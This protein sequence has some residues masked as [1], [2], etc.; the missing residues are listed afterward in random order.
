[1]PEFDLYQWERIVM[2]ARLGPSTKL[3][4]FAL[5]THADPDGT[6]VKPGLARLAVLTEL[7]YATVKRA[8][9]ELM[10]AGL[11]E[12]Y[13]RGNRRRG[14]GD[15]YRL[16]LAEDVLERVE[17]LSP[18][19]IEDAADAITEARA[20]AETARRA[21]KDQGS[22]DAPEPADQG[23][24]PT[25]EKPDQG[26]GNAPETGD[27][28]PPVS[29][30]KPDQGSPEIPNTAIRAHRQPVLGLTSDP[31]PTQVTKPQQRPAPDHLPA[32]P[33]TAH[34]PE[35][36]GHGFRIRFRADGSSACACCRWEQRT[37][38]STLEA[39]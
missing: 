17:W 31:L 24:P 3:V 16:I 20:E 5:R 6:R 19:Q 27:Q 32:Q 11:L 29:P 25:P 9:R 18:S 38:V 1:M 21:K 36:C 37:G 13:R 7:S 33:P 34:G 4:A 15:E 2:A 22:Q 23:S 30:E 10:R 39:V 28:G 8:R 35:K 14:Q 26:S 12:L